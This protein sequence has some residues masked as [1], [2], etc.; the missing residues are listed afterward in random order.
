MNELKHVSVLKNE[1]LQF[2]P[3]QTTFALDCT[4]GGGG[5][6]LTL[7]KSLLNLCL[8]GVD[9]DD[10]ALNIAKETL[11]PY[12]SQCQYLHT[13]FSNLLQALPD[14]LQSNGFDYIIADLGASSFQ[15]DHA[16]RGFSFMKDARL[17][18]R[19]S[20]TLCNLTAYAIINEWEEKELQKIF[21]QYG[22]ERYTKRI[23]SKILQERKQ[24]AIETTTQLARI[25]ADAV[26]YRHQTKIHPATRVFQALRIAV[27]HEL[28]EIEALLQFAPQLL[29]NHGRLAMISFHSLEDRLVKQTFKSWQ[30]PCICPRHFPICQCGKISLGQIMTR[31][32]VIPTDEE[33]QQNPRSRSAKLRVFEKQ[34]QI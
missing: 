17:D 7:L 20:P 31:K 9:R 4:L 1:I 12:H 5:H 3:K 29:K 24:E 34:T 21:W 14:T 18:M 13:R 26:P 8:I 23:V 33:I 2:A 6:S 16:S 15:F 22:E 19:M 11:Q 28:E 25:V 27:N 32:P 30:K 10:F